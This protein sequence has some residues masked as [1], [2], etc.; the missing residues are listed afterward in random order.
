MNPGP[1]TLEVVASR[2][3]K[4]SFPV[5]NVQKE[6]F[7]F[8]FF[9]LLLR[10]WSPVGLEWAQKDSGHALKFDLSWT[11]Q[12]ATGGWRP[13]AKAEYAMVNLY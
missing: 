8:F 9:W 10:N 6:A 4:Y 1:G 11:P 3:T 2:V 7:Y 13:P 12:E 5:P